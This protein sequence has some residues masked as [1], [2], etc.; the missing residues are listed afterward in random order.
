MMQKATAAQVAL[1]WVL[2][3]KAWVVP[4]PRTTKLTSLE[5]SLGAE[6]MT[7]SADTLLE[8]ETA[9]SSIA[10]QGERYP[11]ALEKQTGL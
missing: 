3:R 4:I 1:A 9:A 11:E 10:I 7:L 6:S 8:I 5:E 2:A